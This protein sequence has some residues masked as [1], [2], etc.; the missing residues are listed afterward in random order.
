MAYPS[1][2]ND[3]IAFVPYPETVFAT[4]LPESSMATLSGALER[5]IQI[6]HELALEWVKRSPASADA[7]ESLADI[8]E[9][10]GDLTG[11]AK[12][13]PSAITALLR[14]QELAT[15]DDQKVRIGASRVRLEFKLGKFSRARTLGD[16]LLTRYVGATRVQARELAPIAALIG[17]LDRFADLIK[18]GGFQSASVDIPAQLQEVGA[19]LFS[20]AALGVCDDALVELKRNLEQRLDSY[21]ADQHRAEFRDALE[22][23]ALSLSMPCFGATSA[24]GIPA[25][26]DALYKMQ[27]ALARADTAAVKTG[28]LALARQ[29]RAMRPGDVSLDYIYQEAWLRA[30]IGDTVESIRHLDRALSALPALSATAL[31][32]P[33]SAAAVGRAMMLRADLAMAT[34]DVR[35]A[36]MWSAAVAS[37]WASADKPLHESIARM[38]S[39]TNV[40]ERS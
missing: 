22:Q 38:K 18:A 29:R 14:A 32:Q 15:S 31:K 7:Q 5:D 6:R 16:S 11:R 34:G 24:L 10:R 39:L 2:T 27:R 33:A 17:R 20:R 8:L 37:L 36:R 28:F 3:T 21:A 9:T 23:R 35:S 19:A 25:G 12:E 26:E 4:G 13:S 1:L 30:A 40:G